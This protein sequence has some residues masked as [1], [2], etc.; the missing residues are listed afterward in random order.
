M[1]TKLLTDR[2]REL[3]AKWVTEHSPACYPC[4]LAGR[5][6]VAPVTSC[7]VNGVDGAFLACSECLA[8]ALR[9]G[10]DISMVVPVEESPTLDFMTGLLAG[11][12]F[13]GVFVNPKV[14]P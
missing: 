2:G 4:G 3:V 11:E 7:S 6:G 9:D 13:P 14:A 5:P 1:T 10:I 8:R 12:A